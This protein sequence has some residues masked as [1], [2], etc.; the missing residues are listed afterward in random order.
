M[1]ILYDFVYRL[2]V[3]TQRGDPFNP[4]AC[5]AC[6][7]FDVPHV[8]QSRD[9]YTFCANQLQDS[10]DQSRVPLDFVLS[11]CIGHVYDSVRNS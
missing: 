8:T 4:P 6:E 5:G 1:Y 10:C 7:V 3:E 11:R 9:V 2:N